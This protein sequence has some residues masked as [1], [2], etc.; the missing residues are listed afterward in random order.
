[1]ER[2]IFQI[3][4]VGFA[5]VFLLATAAAGADLKEGLYASFETT[6]GK[7]LVQLFYK[8]TPK[9]VGNFVGLA[10]GLHS[11]MGNGGKM[12]KSKFYDGL[13][14]HRVIDDFMIQGGDPTGS[15]SGG[16]GYQFDDE[17]SDRKH[18]GPGIL[19]MANSG[20][21]T[22]GSQFFITHKATPWLDDKHSVFGKVTS[23]QEIVDAIS[24]GDVMKT[25]TISGDATALLEK[26]KE[27][28]DEWNKILDEK[29]PKKTTGD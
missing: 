6:K 2:A 28:L 26:H 23:S 20:P 19:S 8:K 25:I 24:K 4:M 13:T 16:P 3:V 5:F 1:M 21:G 14:F 18:D 7:I 17:I 15:G 10:E 9:T 27:Q 22:N 11:W 29:F 12:K